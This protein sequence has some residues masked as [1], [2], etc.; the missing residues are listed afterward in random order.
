MV[1]PLTFQDQSAN[2]GKYI[3]AASATG[4]VAQLSDEFTVAS[5]A[6]LH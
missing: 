1:T 4:Y 5:G 3:A 6:A 2:A